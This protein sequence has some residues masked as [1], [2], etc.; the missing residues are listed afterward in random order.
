VPVQ[1]AEA[2][3]RPRI[4]QLPSRPDRPVERCAASFRTFCG[5]STRG[6]IEGFSLKRE[7]VGQG[8]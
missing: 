7:H 3:S 4:P 5:T 8:E 2:G 1:R 6:E